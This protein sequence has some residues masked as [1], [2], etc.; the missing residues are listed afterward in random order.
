[1]NVGAGTITCNYDGVQKATTRIGDGAFIGSNS[2]LVAPVSIGE[3]A[4]IGAGSVV[5]RDAPA[6]K[7]TVARE[8]QRTVDG[9]QRPSRKT[10]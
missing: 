6:G 3:D 4:T 1:V 7:L 5:T 9:W 10:D 2:A 8:R